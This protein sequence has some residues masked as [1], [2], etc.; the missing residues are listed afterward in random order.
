MRVLKVV[1]DN[2]TSFIV[3][4]VNSIK[5]NYLV[6]FYSLNKRKEIKYAKEIQT[7]L[8]TTKLPLIAFLDENF[9]LVDGIWSENNPD[10]KNEILNKIN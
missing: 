3:D 4:I 10:W 5:G 8:G 6:D 2:K 1:Y 9:E 7:E